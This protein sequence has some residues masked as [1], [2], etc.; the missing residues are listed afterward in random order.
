MFYVINLISI[1]D[2]T[3]SPMHLRFSIGE[4]Q[5]LLYFFRLTEHHVYNS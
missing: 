4:S 1:P 2:T 3:Q 5:A